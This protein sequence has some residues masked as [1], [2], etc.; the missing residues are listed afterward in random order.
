VTNVKY[1]PGGLIDI[2][3]AVQYLQIRHGTRHKSLR[4][5][6]TLTALRALRRLGKLSGAYETKLTRTYRF[7]RRLV[8]ALRIVRGNARDLVLPPPDS[9]EFMF[10]ARRMGYQAKDWRI[11]AANLQRDIQK[12]MAQTRR[13]FSSRFE[14]RS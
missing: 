11:A 13:F 2:E 12:H 5:P 14:R 7:L 10:L 6:S 9:E 3:Y 8:D 4:S 1:S